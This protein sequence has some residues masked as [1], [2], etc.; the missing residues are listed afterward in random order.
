MVVKDLNYGVGKDFE[1]I[2]FLDMTRFNDNQ[3]HIELTIQCKNGNQANEL[4]NSLEHSKHANIRKVSFLNLHLN[5]DNTTSLYQSAKFSYILE[6]LENDKPKEYVF[7]GP[8]NKLRSLD[9]LSKFYNQFETF[10][11]WLDKDYNKVRIEF[12]YKSEVNKDLEKVKMNAL[13]TFEH[14]SKSYYVWLYPDNSTTSY[15]LKE[16]TKFKVQRKSFLYLLNN[17]ASKQEKGSHYILSYYYLGI[18]RE[19]EIIP[20]NDISKGL[21]DFLSENADNLNSELIRDAYKRDIEINFTKR[22]NYIDFEMSN[23]NGR[24]YSGYAFGNRLD[25]AIYK[26][27]DK[28]D[29]EGDHKLRDKYIR[30]Y[31]HLWEMK[32][33]IR[34]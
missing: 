31:N 14:N 29:G 28:I 18:K 34:D 16:S 21:L 27:E 23:Q 12:D 19:I 5:P 13:S 4:I 1:R 11:Y 10:A 6:Y 30:L 9:Y 26:L 3:K 33:F 32:K 8:A 17:L 22:V 7:S 15:I 2:T 20:P 24:D 25:R